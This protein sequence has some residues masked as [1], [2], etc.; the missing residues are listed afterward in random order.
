M[1]IEDKDILQG[2]MLDKEIY[3]RMYHMCEY[4]EHLHLYYHD[5]GENRM[6]EINDHENP[7][8]HYLKFKKDSDQAGEDQTTRS[9]LKDLGKRIKWNDNRLIVSKRL[10][11]TSN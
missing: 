1:K 9:I 4:L 7:D 11:D 10:K 2:L 8:E 5:K 3:D 6:I